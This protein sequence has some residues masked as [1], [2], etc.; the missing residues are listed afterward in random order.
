MRHCDSQEV[1]SP[2]TK[3]HLEGGDGEWWPDRLLS[4]QQVVTTLLL[5]QTLS[6]SFFQ[7]ALLRATTTTKDTHSVSTLLYDMSSIIL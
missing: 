1:H 5:T 3:G 6:L 4:M 2:P 7:P